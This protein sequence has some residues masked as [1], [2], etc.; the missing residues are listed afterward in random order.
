MPSASVLAS[1]L[2]SLSTGVVI[3]DADERIRYVGD[4]FCQRVGIERGRLRDADLFEALVPEGDRA[5]ARRAFRAG[6]D[7]ASGSEAGAERSDATG[8]SDESADSRE[9]AGAQ[10]RT[11]VEAPGGAVREIAWV[12]RVRDDGQSFAIGRLRSASDDAGEPSEDA[13][14]AGEPSEDDDARFE[15]YR[16]MVEHFPG[17]I[18]T[19]FDEGFRYRVVGGQIFESLS[20]SPSDLEGRRLRDVFPAENVDTLRPYYEA[21]LAG[22]TNE[23]TITF[24]G[25]TFEI[26]ILPVRDADGD[27]IAGMTVSQDVTERE[28]RERELRDAR[29]R[30]R[31]LVET[32]PVPIFVANADGVLTEVNAEAEALVGREREE[33]VGEPTTT[34]HPADDADTYRECFEGHLREG[35]TRRYYDGEQLYV[36]DGDGDRIPVEISVA[37]ADLDDERLVHGMFRDISDQVWYEEALEELHEN[38]GALVRAETEAEIAQSIAE[39]AAE[40]LGRD[41][42]T[43]YRFAPETERLFPMAYADGVTEV[44]GDPPLLGLEETIA[45]D[46][47][48]TG[49]SRR[50]DDVRLHEKIHNPDTPVRSELVVPIEGFGVILCGHTAVADFDD[51]DQRLLELLSK[52]AEAVFERTEREQE[53]RQQRRELQA[54]ARMLQQ[55][56]RLNADIRDIV[57][58]AATAE[59]RIELEQ[60]VCDLFSATDRFAFVWV[61]ELTPERDA[62]APRAWAGEDQGYLDDATLSVGNE[63]GP[64]GVRT[65]RTG[66]STVVQNTARNVQ[67]RPW[68]RDAVRRGFRAAISVPL[69]RQGVLYGVLT[70]FAT[71]RD[72][73]SSRVRTVI[74]E[75]GE[76]L[77]CVLNA[78]EWKNALLS[79]RGTEL[80]FRLRSKSCPLLRVAQEHACSF[81]F[82]GL[83]RKENGDTIVFVR[84]LD[85]PA[86][87]V[88]ETARQSTGIA[89]IR[90]LRET[91]GCVSFQ[92][93]FSEPFVAT[94]LVKYGLQLQRITGEDDEQARI[95]ATIPATMP[96]HRAVEIVSTI[97]PNATLVSTHEQGD[98]GAVSTRST[99]NLIGQLTDRQ[100]E[101]LEL[102]YHGGYFESPKGLSGAEIAEKMGLSSSAFHN[103]LRAA[104]RKLLGTVLAHDAGT[105]RP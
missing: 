103:H 92:I 17:G 69:Q 15:P 7:D 33:L 19:L 98:P 96:T 28:E 49:E 78:M 52:N 22:E 79:H 59:T 37:T 40:T 74:E 81:F 89:S 34:L 32:A 58:L 86:E 13:D 61:G 24:E 1:A 83:H 102:A 4:A 67:E 21:A 54:H 9:A 84:L 90:E 99:E 56:E 41:L 12:Q 101:V 3:V 23:T 63:R 51:E 10:R 80:G 73:F 6:L 97:Y 95:R 29:E 35:G 43:V 42:V 77:G 53:S 62:L 70:V 45:G 14:D 64:P 71:E 31:A 50:L 55:V 48:L 2:D 60:G 26:R 94:E 11:R 36:V 65:A 66:D 39:T 5:A 47:Y 38:A 88:I 72:A 20:L 18:V 57:R 91:N 76:L 104:Q 27:V 30:Y 25:R 68:R 8:P 100:R 16:T 93:S 87:Q 75:C 46:A 44:I 105:E 85:G 82:D